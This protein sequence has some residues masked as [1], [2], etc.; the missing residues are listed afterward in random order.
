MTEPTHTHTLITNGNANNDDDYDDDDDDDDDSD[1]DDDDDDD[2]D[3]DDDD[4][5][6]AHL[7]LPVHIY[8]Q[9]THC[10]A[11]G[12]LAYVQPACCCTCGRPPSETQRVANL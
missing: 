6:V 5:R 9:C 4:D 7:M 1:E 8:A 11:A 12:G 2:D 3:G 10:A